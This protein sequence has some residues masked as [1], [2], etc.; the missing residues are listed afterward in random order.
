M[1]INSVAC[2][3]KTQKNSKIVS[4]FRPAV[5]KGLT[6][7]SSVF[8]PEQLRCTS[9]LLYIFDTVSKSVTADRAAKLDVH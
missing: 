6:Y 4:V 2:M 3:Q 5:V 9:F 8:L 7:N 1:I